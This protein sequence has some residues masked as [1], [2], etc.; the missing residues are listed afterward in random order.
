MSMDKDWTIPKMR[1]RIAD[2]E[3]KLGKEFLRCK[4]AEDKL[5]AICEWAL[6]SRAGMSQRSWKVFWKI[7][8]PD[9]YK[10]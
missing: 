3:R 1:E 2:L 5:G 10:K 4:C 8:Q 9:K 7:V 6:E